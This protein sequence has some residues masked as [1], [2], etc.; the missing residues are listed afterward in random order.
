MN[1]KSL[2]FKIAVLIIVALA[3]TVYLSSY[4]SRQSKRSKAAQAVDINVIFPTFQAFQSGSEA[5]S[6]LEPGNPFTAGVFLSAADPGNK[7]SALKMLFVY[8]SDYLTYK[9]GGKITPQPNDGT[10]DTIIN[11]DEEVV[12]DPHHRLVTIVTL[13]K[14]P[15]GS[16][17]STLGFDLNFDVKNTAPPGAAESGV[18]QFL[19]KFPAKGISTE[20]SEIIGVNKSGEAA[21]FTMTEFIDVPVT[22]AGSATSSSSS[23]SAPD[24]TLTVVDPNGPVTWKRGETHKIKWDQDVDGDMTQINLY[25]SN[26]TYVGP[27]TYYPGPYNSGKHEYIWEIPTDGRGGLIVSPIDGIYYMEVALY[28]NGIKIASGKSG[29]VTIDG[30]VETSSSSSPA[31]KPAGN[32]CSLDRECCEGLM[33]QSGAC[34]GSSC[35]FLYTI[36]HNAYYTSCGDTNYDKRADIN[37]DRTI[38]AL[39]FGGLRQHY[40]DE[41]WCLN[42]LQSTVDPCALS[43]SSSAAG[44]SSS[45]AQGGSSSSAQPSSCVCEESGTCST[46]CTFNYYADTELPVGVVY[47]RPLS[48]TISDTDLFTSNPTAAD[49]TGWCQRPLRVKG[50]SDGVGGLNLAELQKDLANYTIAAN[51]RKLDPGI[52]PDFDGDG[53]VSNLD[54]KI[55]IKTIQSAQ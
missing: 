47:Q 19:S 40:T 24:T 4:L 29:S 44:G 54:R 38:N 5:H 50:D 51:G 3:A 10:D 28:K 23:S 22:V 14:A 55:I 35:S 18:L 53:R 21:K 13:I 52:N 39:D 27:I 46:G 33:C 31:C 8:N 17:G 30:S 45:S 2:Y 20:N 6:T 9:S 12:G 16:L 41:N 49:R 34:M 36:L 25:K 1:K 32:A 42:Q 7:I 11:S 26:N 15:T 37:Q 48:C 43:S